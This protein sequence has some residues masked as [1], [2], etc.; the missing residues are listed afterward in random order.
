MRTEF[1]IVIP[2]KKCNILRK[3]EVKFLPVDHSGNEL[4]NLTLTLVFFQ[5][6]FVILLHKVRSQ[7]IG[8]WHA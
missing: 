3:K 1:I 4:L 6:I 2:I 8:L 5:K 7:N